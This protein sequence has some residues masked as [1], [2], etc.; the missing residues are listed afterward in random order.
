MVMAS[1]AIAA[2]CVAHATA[3]PDLTVLVKLGNRFCE[4]L[5]LSGRMAVSTAGRPSTDPAIAAK[6]GQKKAT[7]KRTRT[8]R[9]HGG[10]DQGLCKGGAFHG[11]SKYASGSELAR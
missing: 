2:R 4:E 6:R 9:K 7:K 1:L 3:E 10:V 5:A 8:R 11:H